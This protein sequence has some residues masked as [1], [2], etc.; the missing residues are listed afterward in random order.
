MLPPPSLLISTGKYRR[1]EERNGTDSPGGRGGRKRGGVLGGGGGLAE[2]YCPRPCKTCTG[3][4]EF[5][6]SATLRQ[7]AL[8]YIRRNSYDDEAARERMEL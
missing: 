7:N 6:S 1:P 2:E 4:K 3:A 8:V 5:K